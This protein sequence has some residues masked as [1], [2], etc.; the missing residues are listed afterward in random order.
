MYKKISCVFCVNNFISHSFVPFEN[1]PTRG[2]ACEDHIWSNN[3]LELTS[4]IFPIMFNHL[5]VFIAFPVVSANCGEYLKSVLETT[6]S[7]VLID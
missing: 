1:L 2:T 5:P 6:A 4:G 7:N 3:L